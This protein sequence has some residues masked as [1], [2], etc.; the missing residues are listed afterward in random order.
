ML[1]LGGLNDFATSAKVENSAH[2]F[3]LR[4]NFVFPRS[5]LDVRFAYHV[6]HS[7]FQGYFQ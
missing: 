5:K 2:F 7:P 4:D 1:T 3:G 6:S